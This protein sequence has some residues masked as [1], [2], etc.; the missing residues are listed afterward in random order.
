MTVR[1]LLALLLIVSAPLSAGQHSGCVSPVA[2]ASATEAHDHHAGHHHHGA[3]AEQAAQAIDTGADCSSCDAACQAACATVATAAP[4]FMLSLA[5]GHDEPSLLA[6]AVPLTSHP[7]PLL[8]P[9]SSSA[10]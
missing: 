7:L 6:G 3:A 9:P 10:I 1:L 8:R 5:P 4:L 2:A